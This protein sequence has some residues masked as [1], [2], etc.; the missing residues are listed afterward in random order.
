[1]GGDEW[2]LLEIFLK[3]ATPP[4][5]LIQSGYSYSGSR[6]CVRHIA[7]RREADADAAAECAEVFI[8]SAQHLLSNALG[9]AAPES[10]MQA[11]RQRTSYDGSAGPVRL[12]FRTDEYDERGYKPRRNFRLTLDRE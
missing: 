3:P 2:A 5:Y 4:E 6:G 7:L 10:L 12:A 1:L 9:D 11:V 8:A